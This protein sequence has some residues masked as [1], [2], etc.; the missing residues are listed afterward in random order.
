MKTITTFLLLC[1]SCI[2]YAQI[3]TVLFNQVSSIQFPFLQFKSSY[4][5]LFDQNNS[6][7]L[8][9]ANKEYGVG[10]YDISVTGTITPVKDYLPDSLN[11]IDVTAIKQSGNYLFVGLGDYQDTTNVS[12][13][14]AIIDISNPASAFITDIWDSTAFDEGVTHILIEGNYAYLS[15]MGNGLVILNIANKNDIQF[16]SQLVPDLTFPA[17]SAGHHQGRGM[18]FRNDTLFFCF[19]RG[20][21]RIIDVSVKS[22]PVELYKYINNTLISTAVAAYND[23]KV[24]GNYAFVSVDYCGMEILDISSTPYSPVQWYNPWGCNTV[25]WNGADLHAN[26][27]IFEHNDSLLFMA[28]GN[29]ELLV[30]DVSDPLNTT[31]VGEFLDLN[32]GYATYGLDVKGNKV[33]LSYVNSFFDIP[34]VGNWG[35]LKLLDYTTLMV[36]IGEQ[37]VEKP[38]T[39]FPNPGKTNFTVK[40]KSVIN[41]IEIYDFV[42]RKVKTITDINASSVNVNISDLICGVYMVDITLQQGNSR[43]KLVKDE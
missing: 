41:R 11:N 29:S 12:S 28:A 39:I 15:I 1:L 18:D 30:F 24:K 21:L 23:V 34:F 20:G 4:T 9:S 43:L 27:L 17:V 19:D 40:A 6:S 8:Y 26:E 10:I 31:K 38:T 5:S 37:E 36:G 14:L 42:G 13:G 33:S 3:D 32:N 2:G 16:V 35:G 22:A 25:N 7:Y